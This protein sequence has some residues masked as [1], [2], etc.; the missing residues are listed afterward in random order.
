MI[1]TPKRHWFRFSLRTLFV[2][3]AVFCVAAKAWTSLRDFNLIQQRK[4]F[5]SDLNQIGSSK[6]GTWDGHAY[7]TLNSRDQTLTTW[8]RFL[9][10]HSY[11]EIELPIKCGHDLIDRATALFP[12][13]Q[14]CQWQEVGKPTN[15]RQTIVRVVIQ[16][17]K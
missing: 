3:V 14:V 5:T 10:D 8:R 6:G 16:E 12:E 15:G 13:A 11:A 17:G 2:L 7:L 9:N 1:A 4:Q